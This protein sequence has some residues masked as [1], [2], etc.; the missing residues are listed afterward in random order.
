M[1]GSLFLTCWFMHAALLARE[2]VLVNPHAA[3]ILRAQRCNTYSHT[4][5]TH[6]WRNCLRKQ[7]WLCPHCLAAGV[8]Y[9]QLADVVR[10]RVA[11]RTAAPPAE[12][13]DQLWKQ[14][15]LAADKHALSHNGLLVRRVTHIKGGKE[16]VRWGTVHCREPHFRPQYFNIVYNDGKSEIVDSR[17]LRVLRPFPRGAIRPSDL[18]DL[19]SSSL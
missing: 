4:V 15:H 13:S 3:D 18:A 14:K 10:D 9:M 12:T 6:P 1:R 11:S 2:L 7:S 16:V 17:G 19:F 5:W 8:T